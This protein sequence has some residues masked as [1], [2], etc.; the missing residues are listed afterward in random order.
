MTRLEELVA[1]LS[2]E[3]AKC[4]ERFAEFVIARDRKPGAT[5]FREVHVREGSETLWLYRTFGA[6][7]PAPSEDWNAMRLAGP[8]SPGECLTIVKCIKLVLGA[9]GL[10]IAEDYGVDD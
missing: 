9:Y 2:S 1:R 8:M 6:D 3:D 10:K 4:V 7:R 5:L